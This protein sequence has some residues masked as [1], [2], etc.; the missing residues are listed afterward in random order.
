MCTRTLD[1][2]L[3]TSLS[4]FWKRKELNLCCSVL[5]VLVSG[6]FGWSVVLAFLMTGFWTSK[7]CGT[8]LG[9]WLLFIAKHMI[10][11]EEFPS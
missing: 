6:V 5:F 8:C 1:L 3:L 7:Y 2:F 11:L 4:S 10:F 9:I